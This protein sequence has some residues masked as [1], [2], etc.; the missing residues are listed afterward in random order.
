MR[1]L[2][3]FTLSIITAVLFNI[4]P[5]AAQQGGDSLKVKQA[6][7]RMQQEQRQKQFNFYRS[8]LKVDSVKAAQ[9]AKVQEEYKASMKELEEQKVGVEVRRQRIRVLMEKKNRR[10]AG[11]LNARQQDL[12]IP[13]SEPRFSSAKD[14]TDVK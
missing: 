1:L 12:L 5:A 6:A 14:S 9:V 2:T 8:S 11:I 7:P 13:S 3:I 4:A 10:L